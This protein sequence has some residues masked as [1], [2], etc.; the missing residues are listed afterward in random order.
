MRFI[1]PCTS[2]C[3]CPCY[4]FTGDSKDEPT[5]PTEQRISPVK[6]ALEFVPFIEM[7][8]NICCKRSP[9][10]QRI[11]VKERVILPESF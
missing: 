3:I 4:S 8:F 5:N 6:S 2:L 1:L 7:W 11:G 10:S 9:S